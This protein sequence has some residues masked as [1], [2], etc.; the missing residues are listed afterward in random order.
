MSDLKKP[1]EIEVPNQEGIAKTFTISRLPALVGREALAKYSVSNIPKIGD[2]QVSE[3]VLVLLFQY[4]EYNGI[5][6]INKDLINNH[7]DDA[8][9]LIQLEFR[10]LQYNSNLLGGAGNQNIL[11]VLINKLFQKLLPHIGDITQMV[12]G[13]IGSMNNVEPVKPARTKRGK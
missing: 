13:F 11:D 1:L 3:E 2:Y 7:V 8:T 12:S 6:L 9:Q 4:I 5:R 10:M